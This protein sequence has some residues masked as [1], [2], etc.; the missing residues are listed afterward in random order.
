VATEIE[1]TRIDATDL[2]VGMF[3]CRLDRPWESTPFPLQGIELRTQEDVRNLR[4]LCAYVYIDRHRQAVDHSHMLKSGDRKPELR[5]TRVVHYTDAVSVEDELPNAQ[6]ALRTATEMV[7]LIYA[8]VASGR[9]LSVELVE[10][11]V[12]P[13]VASVL[14][15]ADA[16]LYLEGMRRHDGYTYSHAIA[17]SA[18]A[19]AFGRHMGLHEDT[20]FSLAAGGLLM[21]VG[22]TRVPQELLQSPNPLSPQDLEVVRSHIRHGME[23][24]ADAGINDPDVLAALRTHHERHDGG[25]YPQRLLGSGIPVPGRMLGIIDSYDAMISARPYRSPISRH[26]ALQQI[27]SGRNTL[28]QSEL[29]EQFQACLGVYPTGSLV[30]LSSG[31]IA[32][33]I[34][35]NKVRRLRPRVLLLTTP[36]KQPLDDFQPLDLL[37]QSID[38][39]AVEIVRSVAVG[40]YG[41]DTA[42]LLQQ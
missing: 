28:F 32:V 4:N 12:R 6:A 34:M 11:A 13:L 18:L 37:H 8:D 7:D 41:I 10:R 9:E 38:G 5:F 3:V 40:E 26:R 15:S 35:Q 16:F 36:D 31:E 17:C 21:D 14:R 1:E 27:Y 23:I 33:V 25:G 42:G 24:A 22:K 39:N 29:V 20:V 19:A 2:R 30:E